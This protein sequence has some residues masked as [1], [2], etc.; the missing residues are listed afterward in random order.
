MSAARQAAPIRDYALIGDCHGSALVSSAGSIDWCC[1][2]RFDSGSCFARL[3]DRDKGGYCGISLGE[4]AEPAHTSSYIDDTLVLET[5]LDGQHATV[6]VLDFFAMRQGGAAEPGR[7]LIRVVECLR[8][9]AAVE[10][11]IA[12]RFDYGTVSPWLHRVSVDAFSAIGGDDGLLIWSDRQLE[13]DDGRLVL[14]T[15]AKPLGTGERLR[16]LMRFVRPENLDDAVPPDV[17]TVDA[18]LEET[19]TWWRRW[20]SRVSADGADQSPVVRS[21]LTLKALAYAP[22]GAIVAAPTTSLPEVIGGER[23][24]DYRF[25]WIRDSTL[26]A[27]A[28]AQL[29]CEREAERFRQFIIRSSAGNVE[30]LQTLVGIGGE[31]RIIEQ[32]LDLEGYRGSRPVRVGNGAV[33]QVQLDALGEILLLAWRW[34][35]RGHSPSD[36]EWRFFTELVEAAIVRWPEPDRG[37]WEWRPT[38]RHFVHSKAC[39]WT[40]VDCGLR[41][42]EASMRKAPVRRW[43]RAREEIREAIDSQG[44]DAKR[45]VFVQCFGESALDAALLLLPVMGYV[46]F[47][48]ERMVRTCDAIR[49]ELGVAGFIRRYDQEDGLPGKEGAFL[50]CSFWLAECY[51]R[52]DRI[53]D[54]REVFDRAMSGANALGLFAEQIDPDTGELLG[55]FPQALT[56]LSHI[57]AAVAISEATPHPAIDAGYTS[58]SNAG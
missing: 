41:I 43:K 42:A 44:Y 54:A 2:P 18:Q 53:G 32:D 19:I 40:A 11:V 1:Q 13:A 25:S 50:A 56:H 51:A 17:P 30:D 21:V 4:S 49:E 36:D 46:A 10:I 29:G 14:R 55:N 22:T 6:R 33:E 8:G 26:S 15:G 27:S 58:G 57:G 35:L 38:P 34:H 24:W 52:Q 28:L 23:N 47:D 20:R 31:R 9:A 45:G 12:P 37:I 7:E 5:I 39:C 48:D 3:L 16:L